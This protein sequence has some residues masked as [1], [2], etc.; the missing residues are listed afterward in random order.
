M[1]E[2]TN[3]KLFISYSWS[4]PDHEEW[5]VKLAEELVAAGVHVILDK[6][7]LREGQESAAFMEQMVSDPNVGKVLLICDQKYQQRADLRAGGV[8]TEAQI[9]SG[10]IYR[11]STQ[12]KFVAVVRERDEEG[13]ACLPA[14]YTSRI[15][16]DLSDDARYA[17]EF[18]RLVRWAYDQPLHTRPPIGQ[19][20]SFLQREDRAIK[21]TTSAEH[22]RATDAVKNDRGFA[23]AAIEDYFNA[24][25]EG[26]EQFRIK[27]SSNGDVDF[28]DQVIK[29]ID[30]FLPYRNEAIEL[31]ITVARYR[32]TQETRRIT[33]RFF[34][35]LLPYQEPLSNA[36]T[37]FESDFDNFRFIVH[38]LFL[39]GVAAFVK[40]ERFEAVQSLLS[41]LYYVPGRTAYGIDATVGFQ[42]FMTY[43]ESFVRRNQRL[44]LNKKTLRATLLEERSHSS[45]FAFRDIM[46]ADFL[47]F[48]RNQI[49]P[50]SSDLF[51][52][53]ETLVYCSW[54]SSPFEIFAR[55][56]SKKYF[57]KVLP[58][59]GAESKTLLDQGIAGLNDDKGVIPRW[60]GQSFSPRALMGYEK[61]STTP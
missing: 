48:I 19:R 33:H 14:Y 4:S 2:P 3:P 15:Y 36:T 40:A 22:R 51:W 46:Q 28:D 17:Q 1:D 26:F 44:R 32:D 37:Y 9:I 23:D 59:L 13:R 55:S 49:V 30:D 10:E 8:G 25:A 5:V 41:T 34:E 18:E 56:S 54:R 57:E 38:E 42:A 47:L 7:D 61:L 52:Y 24:L 29:S 12:T 60:E 21:L 35:R 20:P 43:A 45:G 58:L 53:P 6:W 27:Q 11:S 50:H 16:I 31:F 39:Y